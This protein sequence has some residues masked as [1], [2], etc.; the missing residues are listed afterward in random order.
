M[1]KPFVAANWKMN[2]LRDSIA[3]LLSEMTPGLPILSG[4]I[5]IV[6]C[7]PFVYLEQVVNAMSGWDAQIGGQNLSAHAPGAYTGEVAAEMLVDQGCRYAIVGHSER[8]TL[9]AEDDDIVTLK[10]R[11]A[12]DAGLTPIICVGENLEER[13]QGKTIDVVR[14][15]LL[16]VLNENE[17][18][19][20]KDAIIAYEPVWAIGTGR[21]ASPEQAQEVHQAIRSTVGES[22]PLS[23]ENVRILYGGSVKAE[24]ARA[25]FSCPD[26]DGGLIGG[27][28]LV[29]SEFLSICKA[30]EI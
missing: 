20:L 28:S 7:P 3:A 8:R 17:G 2:G 12:V 19:L 11:R 25:L 4:K 21:T 15:Q 13:D 22:D 29:A 14:R 1:R 27:A 9:F 16:A 18:K 26:I 24:N 6:L 30:A 5:D 10:S 23:A